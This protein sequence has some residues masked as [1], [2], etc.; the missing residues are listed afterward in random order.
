MSKKEQEMQPQI[1]IGL[2]GHVD[3][4]K[5]TLTKALSGKWTDTHSEE[6]KRGI[7]IR[8]GYA[9]S[10]F[11]HNAKTNE[12]SPVPKKDFEPKRKVSFIDAPGHESLMAT[13][14]AGSMIMDGALLLVSANEQCPQPQTREHLSALEMCGIT[15]VIV[16]QN[17]IDLVSQEQAQE[18]YKQIKEFLSDSTYKDAPIIPISAEHGI[19]I[20]FLIQAIEQYIP[21]PKRENEQQPLMLVARSFDVNKPGSDPSQ[22]QGGILGGSLLKGK[23]QVGDTIEIRPGRLIE[24]KNQFDAKP[25]VTKI[26]NIMAGIQQIESAT[27]GGSIA[28]LTE[29]DPAVVKGDKLAGNV[30]GIQGELPPVW[31]TIKLKAHL[32]KRVVGASDAAVVEPLRKG[33]PLMLNVNAA[34]TV[35]FIT[36]LSKKET[37]LSLRLPVCAAVGDRVTLSRRIANRFRLIGY[38]IITQ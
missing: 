4:G 5:T 31:S 1:N 20:S 10:T 24:K 30:V 37:V 25:Y 12:Y 17:K 36:E 6:L 13:M 8:L 29:L 22:M 9:D 38:G 16:V 21:T 11:Y 3:H 32:L 18:N 33:E 35:G 15:N 26:T 27:P 34:T 28:L 14:L 19:N 23:L 7:T 2:V